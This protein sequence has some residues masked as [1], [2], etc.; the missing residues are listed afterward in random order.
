MLTPEKFQVDENLTPRTARYLRFQMLAN[1]KE[2]RSR[3]V[4][5]EDDK[6]N[7]ENEQLAG[8]KADDTPAETAVEQGKEE[9][10]S[11]LF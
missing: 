10:S 4:E 9:V 8:E 3:N 1:A 2:S 5:N 11:R 7:K 6:E